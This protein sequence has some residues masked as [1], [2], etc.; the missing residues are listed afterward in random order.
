M[1]ALAVSSVNATVY[2][3]KQ[4]NFPAGTSITES[5]YGNGVYVAGGYY[6]LILRSTNGTDWNV[7]K[8]SSFMDTSHNSVAFANG[9]FV[10]VGAN[11]TP[12]GHIITSTNGIDW[13]VQNAGVTNGL[14]KVRYLNGAFWAGGNY[15]TLLKSTDGTNWSAITT[16]AT[17]FVGA[18]TYGNSRY[19]IAA[20]DKILSSTTGNSGDWTL[21]KPD[22]GIGD[23]I[24]FVGWLNDRFYIFTSGARIYTSTDGTTWTQ[25]TTAPI[26]SAGHQVFGGIYVNST[27]CFYGYDGTSYGAFFTSP[28]GDTFT[29][30]LPRPMSDVVQNLSYGNGTFVATG[31]G[32]LAYSTNNMAS[33]R[34]PAGSLM[35]SA[36]GAGL[37]VA[38]GNAVGNAYLAVSSNW[39]SWEDVTPFPA[40]KLNSIAFGNNQFVAVGEVR[41]TAVI[42]TSPDGRTWTS[43]SSGVGDQLWSVATDGA[44]TF[45][46]VGDN[47]TI[48]RSTDNGATWSPQ[49][50][51]NMDGLFTVIYANGQFVAA[52]NNGTVLYSAAGDMWMLGAPLDVTAATT[53]IAYHAGNFV[54]VG[55]DNSTYALTVNLVND[56]VGGVWMPAASAPS[57]TTYSAPTIAT[58]GSSCIL[59]YAD[60]NGNYL[61]ADSA[62][63][64]NWS[65]ATGLGT[66]GW[67]GSISYGNGLF[68]LVGDADTKIKASTSAAAFN[69]APTFVGSTTTLALA[70]NASA[71]NIAALLHA[72]DTDS[73]QTLT[74]TQSVAPNHSGTLTLTS[75]T[76]S[77]G[78][79]DITP[80]GTLT[81]QPANGYTGTETFTV[82]VSDSIA[83]AT[84]QITVTISNPAPA[85]TSISPTSGF[86]PGGTVVTVTGTAFTGTTAVKFGTNNATG[87]TVNSDMEITAVS[88]A[89]SVGTVDVRVITPG[90][91]NT[92]SANDQFTYVLQP[93]ISSVTAP[94]N[95]SYAIGETLEF[96]VNFNK[97]VTVSGTPQ[98]PLTIGSTSRNADYVSGSTS[99]TLLFRYTLVSGDLDMDG[100]A[101][102]S[103]LSLNSGTI[104]DSGSNNSLLTF[105]PPNTTGVL[106]PNQPANTAPS[107]GVGTGI[108][109]I[110]NETFPNAYAI[111]RQP[112]GNLVL[113]GAYCW[114]V[115][116]YYTGFW[117]ARLNSGGALD[118]TFGTS[119]MVQTLIGTDTNASINSVA[120]QSDGKIVAAGVV[121]PTVGSGQQWALARYTSSGALDTSF[122]SG[123]VVISA[124]GED[125]VARRVLI[126]SDGK[127][128]VSG[129]TMFRVLGVT[130]K[131]YAMARY[132]SNGTL[133]SSFGTNGFISTQVSTYDYNYCYASALQSDGKILLAGSSPYSSGGTIIKFSMARYNSD[134]SLDSGFGTNG[135]VATA[136]GPQ[137]DMVYDIGIQ[138]DGKIC[139]FGKSETGVGSNVYDYTVAR[140][141]TNGALDT[142][143]GSSGIARVGMGAGNNNQ[144]TTVLVQPDDKLILLGA[145]DYK[146]GAARLNSDGSLDTAFG[147]SGKQLHTATSYD[148]LYGAILQP[149]G[150]VVMAGYGDSGYDTVV[151]RINASGSLDTSFGLGGGA[152]DDAPTFVTGSSAVVMDSNVSVTDAELA[153][154]NTGAGNYSGATLTLSRNGGANANDVF[155]GSGTLSLSGGNVVESATTVGTYT[156]SGGT[157]VITYN[158][159]ATQALLNSSLQHLAYSNTSLT[160]PSS[161][162][163][164]WLFSDG[165]SGSQGLG[166]AKS[167]SGSI[168]VTIT[169][170][171]AI[172]SITLPGSASYAYGQNLDFT[173]NFDRAVTVSGTPSFN[174]VIGSNTR[175]VTYVS[176]SGTTALVF[177]YTIQAADQDVDGIVLQ[178][179]IALNGGTIQDSGAH[180]ATLTFT[181]PDA[182]GVRIPGRPDLAADFAGAFNSATTS[183]NLDGIPTKITLEFWVSFH[184]LGYKQSL[185]TFI[186]GYPSDY[187]L[188]PY[189]D[190]S[191]QVCLLVGNGYQIESVVNSGVTINHTDA[192][193]HLAFVYEAGKATIY[194]DGQAT[195]ANE[196]ATVPLQFFYGESVQLTAGNQAFAS[197]SECDAQ[198]DELRIWIVGRTLAEIRAY[199]ANALTGTETGLQAYYNCDNQS[200]TIIDDQTPYGRDLIV[201]MSVISRPT[202]GAM[203][204]QITSVANPY[205][206]GM[207]VNWN[208]AYKTNGATA[209]AYW[210]DLSTN[211]S[212]SSLVISNANA[213]TGTSTNITGLSL[214]PGGTYYLRLRAQLDTWTS[215]T[216][217]VFAVTVNS[218]PTNIALSAG[219][220]N[221]T[222]GT[223][224]TV[225][226]LTATDP[227]AG[228]T[229]TYTLVSGTGDTNNASFNIS[230]ATLRANNPL[231]MLAGNYYVRVRATDAGGLYYEKAFTITV[232]DSI[233]PE[234]VR[235][236]VPTDG[237]YSM[238]E[239]LSFVVNFSEPVI[240]DTNTVAP[241]LG[242]TIGSSNRF[243]SYVHGNGSSNLLFS[244]MTQGG[245]MDTNGITLASAL[246]LNGST[247]KDAGGNDAILTLNNAGSTTNVCVDTASPVATVSAPS[248][249]LTGGSPVS[250][251]VTYTDDSF[252]FSSLSSG[253]VYLY[254]TGTAAA[255]TVTVTGTNNI[256]T[257]TLSG[258]T[259]EGTLWIIIGGSTAFDSAGNPSQGVTSTAFTVESTPPSVTSTNYAFANYRSAFAGYTITASKAITNYSATGL[260]LGLTVN[261]TNG[262]ISGTPLQA[263]MFNVNLHVVD[264]VGKAGDGPLVLNVPKPFLSITGVTANNKQYDGTTAATLNTASAAL[265]GVYSGDTV[266]LDKSGVTALFTNKFIANGIS[267]TASGFA[268]S[269]DN[270]TNYWLIQPTVA[271]NIT[272]KTLTIAGVTASNKEYDG[273]TKATIN[274]AVGVLTGV[275]SGE[276]VT[277]STGQA[278]GNF[279]SKAIGTNK[280]VNISGY[281]ISGRDVA[282]YTLAQ[283]TATANISVKA[284]TATGVTANT[285]AYDGTTTATLNWSGATISGAIS[286]DAV[287]LNTASATGAFA[288][289]A[290]GTNKTVTVTG[291]A[292]AGLDAGNYTLSQPSA[293]GTITAKGLTVVGVTANSKVYDGTTTATV[294]A[295]SATLVGAISSDAVSLNTGSATGAFA[296]KTV[297]TNKTVTVAGLAL[298]GTAA[299]NYTLAQPAAT[300]NITAKALTVS[301]LKASSKIYDGATAATLDAGSAT[302]VGAITGDAVT[303]NS[304]SA[305]AAFVDKTKG[306][307]KSV[308]VAGLFLAGDDAFNYTLG[309]AAATGNITAKTLTL[310]GLK[311]VN[312]LYDGTTAATLNTASAQLQGVV[313]GDTVGY[314]LGAATFN[315]AN[316]GTAKPVTVASVSLTGADADNYSLGALAALTADIT[317]STATINFGPLHFVY[318]GTAKPVTASTDPEGLPVQITYDGL[319]DAPTNAGNYAVLAQIT[320]PAYTGSA[321]D[322]LVIAKAPADVA[323]AA[324]LN[325]ST[326]GQ[327]VVF[328]ATV[329]G[330]AAMPAGA[331]VF[332]DG[333]LPLGTN[334]LNAEGIASLTNSVLAA[335]GH[336]IVASYLGDENYANA[337][338]T[339]AQ[340]VYNAKGEVPAVVIQLSKPSVA[341]TRGGPV[342]YTISYNHAASI[343]LEASDIYVNRT[344][345]AAGE[346]AVS[347][348]GDTR[349]VTLHNLT[350]DG[351]LSLSLL[352]GT[353]IDADGGLA[354]AAGPSPEVTVDNTA[355]G[356]A[357]GAPS[358]NV[359]FSIPVD[360][361]VN[362]TG[363]DVVTLAS[364]NVT[365][366]P[367]GTVTGK[368]KVYYNG[369]QWMIEAYD[370]KGSGSF[371]VGLAAGTAA[372]LA[373]N[374]A[375]APELSAP[376]QVDSY[377]YVTSIASGYTLQ[378]NETVFPYDQM[379]VLDVD[380]PAQT[381]T[382]TLSLSDPR[383]GAFTE[384]TLAAQ[385]FSLVSSNQYQ[386]QGSAAEVTASL[387]GLEFVPTALTTV[388]HQTNRTII[389]L[390]LDDGWLN[391][392]LGHP[393]ITTISTNHQPVAYGD[394]IT[395]YN[396]NTIKVLGSSL[397]ANDTDQDGDKLFVQNVWS[398]QP[399]GAKVFLDSGWVFYE[400]PV[401]STNAGSF[402]C[403]ISDGFGGTATATV[404]VMVTLPA[405]NPTQN[406]IGVN[407]TNQT[408]TIRFQG[409]PNRN[410]RVEY[411]EKLNPP[412]TVWTVLA[413]TKAN[414]KGQ[415]FVT[416]SAT[417]AMRLYRTVAE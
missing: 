268:L 231:P 199:M 87:F 358:R 107:F 82:Q 237:W 186:K 313:S 245:E 263:G 112:D 248:A 188:V 240:V 378:Y 381:I 187:M 53:G 257:V 292:L 312:K 349:T 78:S 389:Y 205:T 30:V 376:V 321:T 243:A 149:D 54:A 408:V 308:T 331:V 164:N 375:P 309:P 415:I 291:L 382:A 416:D 157:L 397:V 171:P 272:A 221:Q 155:S 366:V 119:G 15:G 160:P 335:G 401:G 320:N 26:A 138:S 29:E 406:F 10:I 316:V 241:I 129:E 204:P 281:T 178:S 354:L 97:N 301:G 304:S 342:T 380:V 410:Y 346:L 150:R 244:I 89:G 219:S 105:T 322:T 152:L 100:I 384:A 374:L 11:T 126:Q 324:S 387:R 398:A 63:G 226:T 363:E 341:A 198:L 19:I 1:I 91:T 239:Q 168:T 225:G 267:V 65:S 229:F 99:S 333:E 113:A 189:L 49:A 74:W 345:T 388:P 209:D 217:A 173:V 350:G 270:A 302:L 286:G 266:V 373:G 70:A 394:T 348:T 192:W 256:R 142:T 37:Y 220:V 175:A 62:N 360:F 20:S 223:N 180:N 44:G 351:T 343:T 73:S 264:H 21:S 185:L 42:L 274:A 88:P 260:P 71:T 413:H 67:S 307:D 60:E 365:F 31:N 311:A 80:G 84:R 299:A 109:V 122:G 273:T 409:I 8:D 169:G 85:V 403:E 35:A 28:D 132:N 104:R 334:Y 165:N 251:T 405:G 385:G 92:T 32:G 57:L 196:T 296:D 414:A 364:S 396:T 121:G 285:K 305:T 277:L 194:V 230:G 306:T 24:N 23:N 16:P 195:S 134:G 238:G 202:S 130:K 137:Y 339:L 127:I 43:R 298:T 72:S 146:F 325:P 7:V 300:G 379:T 297:G 386:V 390:T 283:P 417:A 372:D 329:T 118:A 45:V 278:A 167:V 318:D 40:A 279:T 271:A 357:I 284:V 176:G 367:T 411:T 361:P 108:T 206:T 102:V 161:V 172:S 179:P 114:D 232:V 191:N 68:R 262:L 295:G 328:T 290:A 280:T 111:A 41:T 407:T 246:N 90:G 66:A 294:I 98:L 317:S 218:T 208:A 228:D 377:P 46:A 203:S 383:V 52:G 269:G 261:A 184:Q 368:T 314:S 139:L 288:D 151:I 392:T 214:T 156:Q 265:V 340:T 93:A 2:Y 212:F 177:R 103:P 106:A 81:Y 133:D 69:T 12:I 128:I 371:Q 33:F 293:T 145:T 158:S 117:V 125:D 412:N 166:G 181:P 391:L 110:T 48:V 222:A 275:A 332:L 59:F 115:T 289:N 77:S 370:L 250:Y 116:N 252:A 224:A 234:V 210:L 233:P 6:G 153:A 159:A 326:Y 27:Y 201:N 144:T 95:G 9:T 236:D 235:V 75:A 356:V 120:V 347:G 135:T 22:A 402:V 395:R 399:E 39:D 101:V 170:P 215:P 330:V 369:F 47:G 193:H 197:F 55:Y 162:Q 353:A 50:Q 359:T 213:G 190:E 287:N 393:I 64:N 344:G 86:T 4:P 242:V 315:N 124:F 227:D 140:Y 38:V 94:T 355:P 216:S 338:N 148:T 123:G 3:S 143:F 404:N 247:I 310:T 253:Q 13:A 207:T 174:I 96:T 17:S 36:Y 276:E 323:L 182:S 34:V 337:S 136:A 200:T 58:D 183:L 5:A 336:L 14:S 362:Y 25:Y 51:P 254:N 211:S 18:G 56:I 76:A 61:A 352:P 400:P 303:L 141:D 131:A 258:F 282:N 79:S 83:S 319:P 154:L 255:T 163:I 147:T 327:A 249:T 259:G